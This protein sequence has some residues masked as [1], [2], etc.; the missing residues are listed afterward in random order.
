[1]FG[2]QG[3]ALAHHRAGSVSKELS[4]QPTELPCENWLLILMLQGKRSGALCIPGPYGPFG[5]F[6]SK[7]LSGPSVVRLYGLADRNLDC[8]SQQIWILFMHGLGQT[9]ASVSPSAIMEIIILTYL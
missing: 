4:S 5:R 3:F 1:M 7:V 2:Y 6:R 8:G 9:C